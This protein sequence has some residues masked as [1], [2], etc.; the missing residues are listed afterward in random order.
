MINHNYPATDPLGE[1]HIMQV[2]L[3]EGRDWTRESNRRDDCRRALSY[4][5]TSFA[6]RDRIAERRVF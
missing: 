1:I 3:P 5:Y 4:N 6:P 2:L